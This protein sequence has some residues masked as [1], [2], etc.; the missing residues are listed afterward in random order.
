MSKKKVYI[1]IDNEYPRHQSIYGSKTKLL[2]SFLDDCQE[3]I[4]TL[5][6]RIADVY[7]KC[8]GCINKI[9]FNETEYSYEFSYCKYCDLF[10][11]INCKK[12]V[13][14][15]KKLLDYN[16]LREDYKNTI[17]QNFIKDGI[18]SLENYI[19]DCTIREEVIEFSD[20]E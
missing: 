20:D 14:C 17:K 5:E 15:N 7:E 13:K 8:S 11:C 1:V 2:E 16:E 12:C 18:K 9:G 19:F 3:Y 4:E 10:F 6:S